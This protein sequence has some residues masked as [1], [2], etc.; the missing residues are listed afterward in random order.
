MTIPTRSAIPTT[1]AD[2]NFRS[3]LEA[4]WAAFFDLVGWQWTYE[5]FDADGYIPDFLIHG[6][7]PLFVEVG[8]CVTGAD[9]EAKSKKADAR[10]HLLQHD[11]LVVGVSPVAWASRE[12]PADWQGHHFGDMAPVLGL[13][14]ER[15]E[16]DFWWDSAVW[17]G[18]DYQVFHALGNWSRQPYGGGDPSHPHCSISPDELSAL[19]RRA[20]ND[21][22]WRGPQSVGDILRGVR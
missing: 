15:Q 6:K 3:R 4:R 11:V 17:A 20:G 19:W 22:Q 10:H 13:L 18:P 2:T 16:F 14:G 12:W 9:Y 5:P 1:Y 21:V 8:P 7:R